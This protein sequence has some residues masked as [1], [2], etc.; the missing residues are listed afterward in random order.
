VRILTGELKGRAIAFKANPDL[1]PTADKIRK[2]LFDMLQGA[3]DEKRVLDLFAGTGA[4]A[5]EALSA[6]A[7]SAAFV[8]KDRDRLKKIRETSESLGVADRCEFLSSDALRAI[9][10]FSRSGDYFDFIFIDPPYDEGLALRALTALEC[11]RCVQDG[12]LLFVET[13]RREDL[14]KRIGS[15]GVV[16]I[17]DYGDTRVCVYR[18][19]PA[20]TG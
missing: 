4:L 16:K 18:K 1:R 9:E 13:R 14:P 8:E 19:I 12:T 2:A 20:E 3:L 17:K 15:L 5:F 6:G 11:S 10:T 7:A